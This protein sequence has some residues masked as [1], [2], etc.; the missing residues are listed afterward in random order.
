MRRL[1]TILLTSAIGGTAYAH[2]LPGLEG[3]LHEILSP[4]HL[5]AL[6]LVAVGATIVLRA[7]RHRKTNPNR[8][9]YP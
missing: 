2:E 3:R 4:H 9:V 8:N 1:T 5:P 7:I 6:L